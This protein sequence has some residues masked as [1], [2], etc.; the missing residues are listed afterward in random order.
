MGRYLFRLPDVGEGVAEAEIVAWHVALGGEIFEDQK[1]V[2]VMTDKATVEITSPVT[3]R[4]VAMR[5]DVGG[6]L[7]VGSVFVEFDVDGQDT[8]AS[9]PLAIPDPEN[10][11]RP[12]ALPTEAAA[13]RESEVSARV[14]PAPQSSRSVPK[15]MT[16]VQRPPA[17]TPQSPLAAPATRRRA[18]E[19]GISLQSVPGT[20][21]GGRITPEDL[22]LYIAGRAAPAT[23]ARYA[24]RSGNVETRIIGLRRKIAEKMQ[25]SKR[26]IPHINY[27]EECDVTELEALRQTLNAHRQPHQPKLTLLPFF[28]R[29]LVRALPAFPQINSRYD[30]DV[31]VLRTFEA[32]HIGVATQTPSGLLV[33]VIQHAETHDI[34]SMATELSRISAAARSGAA[35]REELSGS[36]ITLTSLGT[37]GGIVSTPVI[38]HPEVAIV[39]PNKIVDRPVLSGGC[40]TIR[41][42]MNISSAFDHRIID[43]HDAASFIQQIKRL[44]EHP[45]LIFMDS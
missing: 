27:V 7:P 5:G 3:G 35:A 30:D 26:R 6:K 29:A 41:K 4:V 45:A 34:W 25:E 36:T 20:G 38:N 31:G 2:D 11:S 15:P 43:G 39:A 9:R 17:F 42:I 44:I 32:I 8:E 40:V 1:L 33:P 16:P 13:I 28:M 12:S 37:L 10:I 18:R 14:V 22:D 21:R 19:L 23:D 24:A